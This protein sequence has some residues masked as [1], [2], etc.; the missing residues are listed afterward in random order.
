MNVRI[1][2]HEQKYCTYGKTGAADN[3]AIKAPL[4]EAANL[5]LSVNACT[6]ELVIF[7][8]TPIKKFLP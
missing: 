3:N 2:R 7:A 5:M 6:E 1:A 4:R 8:I